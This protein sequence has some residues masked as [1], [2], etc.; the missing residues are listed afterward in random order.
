ML[1]S[2]ARGRK[3]VSTSTAETVGKIDDYVVDQA[4]HAVV[5]LTLKK[6]GSGDT[7]RWSA[8]TAFGTDAVTVVGAEVITPADD[9]IAALKGKGHRLVGG[10]VLSSLGDEMGKVADVEFDPE[11]GIITALHLDDQQVEGVRLIGVGSYAV[12][13]EAAGPR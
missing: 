4:S 7:L 9:E 2:E 3:V 8:M 6:S 10:R 1:F 13:V 11:T 5:A 12:V